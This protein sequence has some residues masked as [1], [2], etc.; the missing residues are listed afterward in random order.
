MIRNYFIVAIRNLI[1]YSFYSLINIFGLTVGI[2]SVLVI[3]LFVNF[4]LSYDSYN[5]NA[6]RIYR[7]DWELY[8][9]GNHTHKA[10]VTPPM[11]EVLVKDFPE[12]EAATRFR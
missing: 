11:A 2:A 5:K 3:L 1:K 12:V 8:L 7:V 10:A 4:E 9:N 6:D